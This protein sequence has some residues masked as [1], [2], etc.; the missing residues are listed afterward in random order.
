[1]QEKVVEGPQGHLT[2]SGDEALAT[3]WKAYHDHTDLVV[4][5][6]KAKFSCEHD[7]FG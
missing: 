6:L 3:G 2:F 4:I 5:G 7:G 1:M